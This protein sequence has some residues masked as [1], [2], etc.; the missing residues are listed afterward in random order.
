DIKPILG[1]LAI[2]RYN[3]F[4]SASLR[5]S[6]AGQYS[7]GDAIA[8]LESV[9]KESLPDGYAIE[10]T[11]STQQELEA[12]SLVLFIF[13]LAITF[14]YL[15]LVAQYAS[16]TMPVSVMLSVIIAI[17]G[18]LLPMYLLPFLKNNLY[19]QIGIVLLI[20]L[21]SKTAI[22]M[23]EFAKQRREEGET[24]AE[25]AMDAA[26]LRF[27]AVMMTALSFV[28]GV[29]PLI[30]ATGAGAASRMSVGFVVVGGMLLATVV[31]IFFIPP[32]YVAMQSMR[33]R[34][35]ALFK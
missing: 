31:G 8:A 32:L 3:Q 25:A 4:K 26:R 30:F 34:V 2:N 11:G 17:F 21:A 10:W 29:L 1:P 28:L 12:G 19:A 13:A 18:A 14:A 7:T 24:I 22:L 27:R 35:N 5:G 9:A 23:V 16:W 15:F 6:P 20:G 33:E